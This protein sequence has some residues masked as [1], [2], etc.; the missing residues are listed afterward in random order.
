L[1]RLFLLEMD[2]CNATDSLWALIV[3]GLPIEKTA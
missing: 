3:G 2:T 1:N